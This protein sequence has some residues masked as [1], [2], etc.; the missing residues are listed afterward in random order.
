MSLKRSYF[1]Q[2]KTKLMK[3]GRLKKK[4]K[5]SISKLQREI[6]QHCKRIIR[7]KYGN[8]CYT[9]QTGPLIGRNWHTGHMWPKASV[10]A[11]LKYDLRILR[12]QCYNC[13]INH[14]G[15]GAD[16]FLRMWEENGVEYMEQLKK[17]RSVTV[18][19]YPHYEELLTKYKEM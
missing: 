19:A 15:R 13:N 2:K 7:K 10:G 5:Q 8:Y 1:K 14:G 12:P 17:D 3:R 9:C 18:K 4:S 16:F 6:W 11:L